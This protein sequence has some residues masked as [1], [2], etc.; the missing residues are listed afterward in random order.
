MKD[1]LWTL[2]G[3]IAFIAGGYIFSLAHEGDMYRNCK[4]FGEAKAWMHDI[5]CSEMKEVK[6]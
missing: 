3:S 2:F 6:E 4:N 5:K 1:F